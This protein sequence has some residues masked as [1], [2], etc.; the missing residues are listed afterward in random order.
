M[1]RDYEFLGH[2]SMQVYQPAIIE[3]YAGADIVQWWGTIL[4]QLRDMKERTEE[5]GNEEYATRLAKFIRTWEENELTGSMNIESIRNLKTASEW[6]G[7]MDWNFA[8]YFE[9][10]TNWLRRLTASIEQ[11]PTTPPPKQ[12]SKPS[13]GGASAA[14]EPEREPAVNQFGPEEEAGDNEQP[15]EDVEGDEEMIA[16]DIKTAMQATAN[17]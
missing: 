6:A 11:L 16:N 12:S 1:I 2:A 17:Q 5:N 8:N 10:L 7:A 13:G 9:T 15:A 3:A 4:G 14:M